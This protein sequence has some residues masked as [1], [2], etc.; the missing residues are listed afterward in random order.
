MLRC[1]GDDNNV[2]VSVSLKNRDSSSVGC[3]TPI[4]CLTGGGQ[5]STPASTSGLKLAAQ[6][7]S[8]VAGVMGLY[9][10]LVPTEE[11]EA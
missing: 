1:A 4:E 3:L 2:I 5:L 7:T 10:R 11:I 8:C 9:T 6:V